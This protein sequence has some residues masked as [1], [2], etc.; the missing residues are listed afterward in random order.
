[1]IKRKLFEKIIPYL[2][3]K[4]MI[5]I[6][7]PR[8]AGKT[9][10]LMMIKEYL[11]QK[12]K[13]TVFFNIDIEHD[14][15]FF[16]SQEALINQI[17][18]YF[19]D[20]FGYVFIDEIQRKENAGLFLKGI[21]DMNLPY[22][23]IISGSGSLELKEKIHE[24]LA[25]RKIV[26]NLNTLS[27]SE[28]INYKTNYLYKN[29]LNYFFQINK[30]KSEGLFFEYLKFGGYPRVV[31]AENIE[32]KRLIIN[33]IFQG[34]LERD[35]LYLLGIKKTDQF[36]NL[37]KLISSQIGQ[38]ININELSSTLGLSNKTIKLYLWYLEKTFILK[39]ITP[40]YSNLRKE[41]VK[42]PTYY[43]NDLGLRNFAINKFDNQEI[44]S[45]EGFLFQNFIS[46]LIMDQLDLASYSLHFWKTQDKTEVDFILKKGE[47]IIPF[48]VKF[49]K[50]NKIKIPRSLISFINKYKPKKAYLINLDFEK[51]IFINNTELF[52]IPWYKLISSKV[53]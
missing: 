16:V 51:N 4:E 33:E 34:Y 11:E 10:L 37:V 25:G 1:M 41:I 15:Q 31:I 46:N 38:L 8:Q 17:K 13:K 21:Y 44:L 29:N 3:E 7:G 14:K 2:E 19:G 32:K 6:T 23:F 18:L 27:I 36:I 30:I 48:E 20:N 26:F 40:F 39:K 12:G 45:Y 5:L 52:F 47:E 43:F 50:L 24:S 35:I 49:T 42:M 28:F 22:K 9:T 53:I